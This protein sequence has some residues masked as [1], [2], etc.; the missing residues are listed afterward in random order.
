LKLTIGVVSFPYCPDIGLNRLEVLA[1]CLKHISK[2]RWRYGEKTY[3]LH[4]TALNYIDKILEVVEKNFDMKNHYIIVTKGKYTTIPEA[5]NEVL[6]IAR[7]IKAKYLLF[8]DDDVIVPEDIAEKLKECMEQHVNA[9]FSA[10]P[11]I[12]WY[13]REP[14]KIEKP[15]H[16]KG[17]EPVETYHM[18]ATLIDLEKVKLWFNPE[19]K[20]HEDADIMLR[21]RKEGI[22]CVL[23]MNTVAYTWKKREFMCASEILKKIS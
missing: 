11:I 17:C 12:A 7:S 10:A 4:F 15:K 19:K 2:I 21:A 9:G 1:E 3:I 18:G 23:N 5:R 22:I 13:G 20:I 6:S 8:V 16:L 14:P